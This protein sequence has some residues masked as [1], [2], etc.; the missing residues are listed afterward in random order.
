MKSQSALEFV[1]V[2]AVGLALIAVSSFFGADYITSYFDSINSINAEQTTNNVVAATNLVYSQG[3]GAQTKTFVTIPSNIILNRTYISGNEINIEFYYGGHI[4]D[5]YNNAAVNMTG[6]LS[7]YG[8][9]LT[10]YIRMEPSRTAIIFT[11]APVSY[12]LVNTF[13]NSAR[14]NPDNNF[15]FNEIV[16]YSVYLKDFNDSAVDSSI[17]VNVYR[18]DGSQFGSTASTNTSGGSYNGS[19]NLTESGY[20]GKWIISVVD[21]SNQIF[22]TTLFNKY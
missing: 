1:T 17:N 11:D 8:G 13:N 6:S 7:V 5:V 14:T 16:Y 21:T 10:L 2:V 18:T 9:K 12:I 4:K 19:F 22:G 3:V 20:G 15:T